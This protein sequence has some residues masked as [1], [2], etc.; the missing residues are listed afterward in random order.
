MNKNEFIS[1]LKKFLPEPDAIAQDRGSVMFSIDGYDREVHLSMTEGRD[2]LCQEDQDVSPMPASKWLCKRVAKLDILAR[3]ILE[4]KKEDEHYVPVPCSVKGVHIE[5]VEGVGYSDAV[6]ALNGQIK[7]ANSFATSV[8]YLTA[9]A[10]EGKTVVMGELARRTAKAYLENKQDWI[11]VPIELSGRPFLRLD[12]VIIGTL[13]NVYRFRSCYIESFIELVK[14]GY[15]VLGLD[16]FEE[17]AI[18][19]VEGDVVSSLGNLLN[20]L[21]SQGRLVFS[22]RTAYYRYANLEAQ[23]KLF[24][25]FRNKD[26]E[27]AEIKLSKWSRDQFI[28]LMQ[29]YGYT[30]KEGMGVWNALKEALNEDHPILTRAVLARKLVDGL[31]QSGEGDEDLSVEVAKK[32]RGANY[33]DAVAGFIQMLLEREKTKWIS[34]DEIAR[35]LL[36]VDQHE[37]LLREIAEELWRSN[38]EVVNREAL[39]ELMELVS[40][41]Y[42]KLR[43]V[44]VEQCK[45]RVIHHAF[46]SPIND[47]YYGFCHVEFYH[48][49]LGQHLAK[50][51]LENAP[52]SHIR[53]FMDRKLLPRVALDECCRIIR[54]SG[55][56]DVSVE[57]VKSCVSDVLRTSCLSQNACSLLI[58]MHN[59]SEKALEV[60]DLYCPAQI[61]GRVVLANARFEGCVIECI[62]W[63]SGASKNVTFINCEISAVA[64]RDGVDL[65]GISIDERSIPAVLKYYRDGE[66]G[67]IYSPVGICAHLRRAGA[68]IGM[69][70]V[71]MKDGDYEEDRR[72]TLLYKVVYY[73]RV[74]TVLGDGRLKHQLGKQWPRF[75]S[76]VLPDALRY[77]VLVE[78]PDPPNDKQARYRLAMPF[79]ELA[80][81]RKNCG[82]KYET[83]I[84]LLRTRRFLLKKNK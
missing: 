61:L 83:L 4:K 50:E 46:L 65:S 37:L 49:Y 9:E 70:A 30:G 62:D 68:K 48:Y 71:P 75:E 24:D 44:D 8:C 74:A 29:T 22:T 25:S 57:K 56:M 5:E 59:N 76:E 63:R 11:F 45:E 26:V 60:K 53:R 67:E 41:A 17:M 27:F 20:D 14:L 36:T 38:V 84:E 28:A 47:R 82:G 78:V 16:G 43:P 80:E 31:W 32:F 64:L 10:G 6:E 21:D 66:V 13:S 81:L 33:Q 79:A 18:E 77:H 55:K 1:T 52:I 34:K 58:L 40:D 15:I 7:D 23:S 12:E 35:P 42:F 39:L 51:F 72:V 73:Y 54:A 3:A 69:E 19:G 2:V